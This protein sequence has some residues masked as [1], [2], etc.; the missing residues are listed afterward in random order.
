MNATLE[1]TDR[2]FRPRAAAVKLGISRSTLYD[3]IARGLLQRPQPIS[4][5]AVGWR[6]SE[7]DAYLGE[8]AKARVVSSA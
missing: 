7:L 6:E 3:L 1:K 5:R 2:V 4:L 8:R